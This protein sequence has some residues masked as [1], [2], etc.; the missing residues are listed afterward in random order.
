MANV[1]ACFDGKNSATTCTEANSKHSDEFEIIKVTP[2]P[3][4]DCDVT[5]SGE[6]AEIYSHSQKFAVPVDDWKPL[7]IKIQ[8][9]YS[10]DMMQSI[11]LKSFRKIIGYDTFDSI[12]RK[13]RT[14]VKD[15]SDYYNVTVSFLVRRKNIDSIIAECSHH[16]RN[17][18]DKIAPKADKGFPYD[19]AD[20]D[21]TLIKA[22]NNHGKAPSTNSTSD[23][24]QPESN[25]MISSSNMNDLYLQESLEMSK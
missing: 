23:I 2:G 25:L 12:R 8:P 20:R 13:H 7:K 5:A 24:E 15:S 19:D 4:G 6:D 22:M 18:T 9:T 3:N 21:D 11:S 14:E 16:Q 17:V 10:L 1:I